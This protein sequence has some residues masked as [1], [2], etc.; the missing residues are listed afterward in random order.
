VWEKQSLAIALNPK[1]KIKN[2]N[3]NEYSK[4]EFQNEK[5]WFVILF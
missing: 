4:S 1:Y 2:P 3:N 5:D